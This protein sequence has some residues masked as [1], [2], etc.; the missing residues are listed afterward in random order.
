MN[1]ETLLKLKANPFYK[2][3]AEQERQLVELEEANYHDDSDQEPH[4]VEIGA[5][6]KHDS[7]IPKHNVIVTRR[8]RR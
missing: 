2:L 8:K 5:I 3:S 4:M 1:K 6:Q 7:T